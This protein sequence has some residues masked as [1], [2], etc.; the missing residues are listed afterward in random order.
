[1]NVEQNVKCRGKLRAKLRTDNNSDTYP[2]PQP[3]LS[4]AHPAQGSVTLGPEQ[5]EPGAN[6]CYVSVD[7]PQGSSQHRVRRLPTDQIKDHLN[8]THAFSLEDF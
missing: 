1:V 6:F 8:I 5:G 3:R 2:Q 7:A 4:Q